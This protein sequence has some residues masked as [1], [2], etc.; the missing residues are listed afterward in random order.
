MLINL[1]KR[2]LGKLVIWRCFFVC[3]VLVCLVLS[4]Y[5]WAETD[6]WNLEQRRCGGGGVGKSTLRINANV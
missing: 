4:M 5:Y 1:G 2:L 3:A 6:G